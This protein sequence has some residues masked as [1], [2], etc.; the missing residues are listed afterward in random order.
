MITP[1]EYYVL[2][3]ELVG[4]HKRLLLHGHLH[5][6]VT[7]QAYEKN[8]E[9]WNTILLSLE[10]G[11]VLGLNKI[12]EHKDYFGREFKTEELN[13]LVDRIKNVRD[14]LIAHIDLSVASVAE[15]R[16]SFTKANELSGSDIIEVIQALEDRAVSYQKA[17]AIQFDV[18]ELFRTAT[19]GAM[20]D[21]DLWLKSF[22]DPL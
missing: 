13:Q 2:L 21:L 15:K 11:L 6:R 17:F 12:L 20:D 8:F 3:G 22:K 1:G 10:S 18:K 19:K 5:E 7:T 9:T 4:A 16:E 14:K